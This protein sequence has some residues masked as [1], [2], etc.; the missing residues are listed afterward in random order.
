MLLVESFRVIT[1]DLKVSMCALRTSVEADPA[2][3]SLAGRSAPGYM[4]L[5]SGSDSRSMQICG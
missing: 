1:R 5:L 4:Y 3:F 2:S